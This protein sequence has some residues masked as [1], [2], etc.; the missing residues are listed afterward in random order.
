MDKD[1]PEFDPYD[2]RIVISFENSQGPWIVIPDNW[3]KA[4]KGYTD[5]CWVSENSPPGLRI[6]L[7]PSPKKACTN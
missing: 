4:G 6:H 2:V 5:D 1:L 3:K 7:Y